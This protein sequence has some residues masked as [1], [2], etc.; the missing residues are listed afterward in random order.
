LDDNETLLETYD[1]QNECTITLLQRQV[2]LK[3]FGKRNF[4]V[5][6][7]SCSSLN[8]LRLNIEGFLET[9]IKITFL[10]SFQHD[11]ED[12]EKFGYF[13]FDSVFLVTNVVD[14]NPCG[15]FDTNFLFH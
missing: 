4:M 2:V 10:Y 9:G 6:M 8:I 1:I 12:E 14:L 15:F 13:P 7:A 3:V 5:S 11:L